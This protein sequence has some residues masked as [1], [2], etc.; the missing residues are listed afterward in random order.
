MLYTEISLAFDVILIQRVVIVFCELNCI[1]KMN[2][3]DD[4]ALELG[5]VCVVWTKS[6]ILLRN[7]GL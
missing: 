2:I 1:L 7:G 6:V 3:G 4:I 5:K